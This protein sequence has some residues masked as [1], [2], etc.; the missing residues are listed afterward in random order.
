M[1]RVATAV[2]HSI[3]NYVSINCH[4]VHLLRT[5]LK[6]VNFLWQI[7]QLFLSYSLEQLEQNTFPQPF[8]PCCR[9]SRATRRQIAHFSSSGGSVTH[10]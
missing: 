3:D 7:G 10:W 2:Q 5:F 9:G 6:R 1:W 4:T 8:Q